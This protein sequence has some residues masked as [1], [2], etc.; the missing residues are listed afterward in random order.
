MTNMIYRRLG[1]SG[2]KVSVISFG[3]W[4]AIQEPVDQELFDKLMKMSY[5]A[6]IN[7]FDNAEYY[8]HGLSETV[9]GISIKN[10]GFKREDLVISTKI[11][12]GTNG[13]GPNAKGL[14]KKHLVEG[15]N[16]SLKRL[17]LD[18]VDLVFAHRPDPEV[19]MEEIQITEAH[20]IARELGLE[21]PVMEQPQYNI[22]NRERVEKEY[23]PLY[24]NFGL[25]TTIWSPLAH[26]V[27]TGKYTNGIPQGARFDGAEGVHKVHVGRFNHDK[28]KD[29]IQRVPRLEP[30]A[31]QLGCTLP[32]LAIAW[33]IKNPNV[34]TAITAF[35]KVEQFESNIKCLDIIDKLTPEIMNQIDDIFETKPTQVANFRDQ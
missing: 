12:F 22:F 30:I 21:G 20:V 11:F 17:Q 16:A 3:A 32:Q 24:E 27:L 33:C 29:Q 10:N 15:M 4:M 7:F 23:L 25:G 14:S 6:G 8:T 34:S 31:K 5:D 26:G 13:W 35:S 1:R 19:P 28:G 2:L 9:M 18:Y